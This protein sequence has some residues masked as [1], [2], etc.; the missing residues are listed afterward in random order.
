[1]LLRHQA[2][3]VVAFR[4]LPRRLAD[5]A[6]RPLACSLFVSFR[7]YDRRPSSSLRVDSESVVYA[8]VTFGFGSLPLEGSVAAAR[9]PR[10]EPPPPPLPSSDKPLSRVL[11]DLIPTG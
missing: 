11:T 9:R 10:G 2:S 4:P 7:A 1:M 5:R 3:S 8:P 6:R